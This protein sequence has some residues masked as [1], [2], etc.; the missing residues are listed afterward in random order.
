MATASMPLVS[1]VGCGN[2]TIKLTHAYIDNY[3]YQCLRNERKLNLEKGKTY[4]ALINI[5]D[6][7]EISDE[8]NTITFRVSPKESIDSDVDLAS[9]ATAAVKVDGRS[10]TLVETE[11]RQGEFDIYDEGDYNRTIIIIGPNTITAESKV[12]ISFSLQQNIQQYYLISRLEY[13]D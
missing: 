9:I 4:T 2:K 12:Q 1:L 5:F 3:D 6:F 13:I 10:L 7:L 8:A 11:P